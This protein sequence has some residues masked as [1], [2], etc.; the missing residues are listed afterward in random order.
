[1]KLQNNYFALRHGY[2]LRN[3]KRLAACWPEKIPYPLTE[4]GK[5]EAQQ[6]AKKA[7]KLPINL[8]FYSDLMRTRQT[9]EIVAA[10]L[11]LRPR[12]DKRLR[13]IDVGIFNNRPVDELGEFYD[14]TKEL[15]PVAYYQKRFS[16]APPKG[17]NYADVERRM[18]VFVKEMESRF[19]GKGI[20]IV[21]HQRPLTLLEKA[22]FGYP[23]EKFVDLIKNKK[24][25]KTGQLKKII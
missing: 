22:I 3:E 10:K 6:A 17:E 15:K 24:E 14:R 7:K 2:S 20:L 5:K 13:E 8:I 21:S 16:Q 1:M 25:I 12:P 23:L 4:K 9:A 18:L 11:G 19:K